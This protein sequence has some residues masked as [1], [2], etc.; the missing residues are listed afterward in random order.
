[1]AQKIINTRAKNKRDTSANWTAANPVLLDGELIIVDTTEGEVRMKIGD[2]TKK[3]SQ[4]PFEDE[5]LRSL[6]SNKQDKIAISGILK[7]DG[8]GNIT[9]AVSGTDYDIP[10]VAVFSDGTDYAD[11]KAAYDAGKFVIVM[12]DY[13]GT[14]SYYHL[15]LVTGSTFQF[16]SPFNNKNYTVTEDSGWVE[17]Q[18][19]YAR[20]NDVDNRFNNIVQVRTVSLP[21]SSQVENDGYYSQKF[22]FAGGKSNSKVDFQVDSTSYSI[23]KDSGTYLLQPVNNNGL[24]YAYAYGGKPNADLSIQISYMGARVV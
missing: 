5:K 7:G 13:H 12:N 4:L 22:A 21:A 17:S 19:I 6:L 3:Y 23:L 24:F 2:G 20:Q 16:Y 11:I 15:S 8:N 9:A 18:S 1:M 14:K 10:E